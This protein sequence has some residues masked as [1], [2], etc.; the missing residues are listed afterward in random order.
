[1]NTQSSARSLSPTSSDPRVR[2]PQTTLP[3]AYSVQATA[4][5]RCVFLF[6]TGDLPA[7]ELS[8][9]R[10]EADALLDQHQWHHPIVDVTR[11]RSVPRPLELLTFARGLPAIASRPRRVAV[12]VRPDQEQQARLIEKLARRGRLFLAYFLDRDKASAWLRRTLPRTLTL[13]RNGREA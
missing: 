9:A 3:M 4:D 1:M 8:A 2:H 7:T 11:S 13:G 10:S 12:A 5:D 6:H